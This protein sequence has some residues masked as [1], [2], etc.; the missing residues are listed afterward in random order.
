MNAAIV[1]RSYGRGKGTNL[2]VNK[3]CTHCGRLGH[4]VD[5]GYKKHGFPPNFK[6]KNG[7]SGASAGN[8]AF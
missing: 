1:P 6:F 4:M 8:N 2:N 7:N 3:I 5:V